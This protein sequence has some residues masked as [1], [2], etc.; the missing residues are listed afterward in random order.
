VVSERLGQASIGIAL[1]TYSHVL[2][3]MQAQA[4]EKMTA[5]LTTALAA[6]PAK[7][8]DNGSTQAARAGDAA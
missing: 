2:P 6:P 5:I 8:V 7:P 3:G 1:E 4:A